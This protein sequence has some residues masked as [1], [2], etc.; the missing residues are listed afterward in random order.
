V[1]DL[2]IKVTE[3]ASHV[4]RM[5]DERISKSVRNGKFRNKR[6]VGKPRTRGE[7]VFR[8]KTSQILGI[9]GWRRP[10]EHRDEWRPG[11][12]RCSSAIDGKQN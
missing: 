2:K 5:E 10:A 9:R 12:R 4:I 7:D 1:D 8:R 11:P 6:A 3:T